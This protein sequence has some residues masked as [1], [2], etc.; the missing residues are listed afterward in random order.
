MNEPLTPYQ[1]AV[2]TAY[3]TILA[4]IKALLPQ[5]PTPQMRT[6][7]EKGSMPA[8]NPCS[9]EFYSVQLYLA[10]FI[11]NR[12]VNISF[13]RNHEMRWRV[14]PSLETAL[15]RV[16]YRHTEHTRTAVNIEDCL[17][18]VYYVDET[19]GQAQEAV[20]KRQKGYKRYRVK[21]L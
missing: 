8:T 15:V 1:A 10:L 21:K 14:E 12:G 9:H 13:A 18:D 7:I 5:Y 16:I 17:E 2:V 6:Y 11:D 4:E 3:T 20:Q 19:Y